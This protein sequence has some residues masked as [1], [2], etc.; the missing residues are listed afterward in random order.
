MYIDFATRHLSTVA[1]SYQKVLETSTRP[2]CGA[3]YGTEIWI[4]AVGP[5]ES[6]KEFAI[7]RNLLVSASEYFEGLFTS[8]FI[9]IS[10]KRLTLAEDDPKVFNALSDWLYPGNCGSSSIYNTNKDVTPDHFCLKLY[11]MADYFD[12]TTLQANTIKSIAAYLWTKFAPSIGFMVELFDADLP[13]R[14]LERLFVIDS[15]KE[16]VG[17]PDWKKW[18]AVLKSHDRFGADVAVRMIEIRCSDFVAS[19]GCVHCADNITIGKNEHIRDEMGLQSV[20]MR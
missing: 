1:T 5:P 10:E 4:I 15:G 16:I 9:E 7:H 20:A 13:N 14:Y 12:I 2:V 8:S 17:N 6:E 18:G 11:L 3:D 19:T